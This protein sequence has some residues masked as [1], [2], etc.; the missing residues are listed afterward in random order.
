MSDYPVFA[1]A[2]IAEAILDIRSQLPKESNL[3]ILEKFPDYIQERF[4]DKKEQRFFETSIKLSKA[5]KHSSFQT[6]SGIEGYIFQ[7]H[8]AKKVVQSRLDGF[9]FNKLKPYTNWELFRSEGHE[10]W[11]IYSKIAK[12]IKVVR[13]ALRYINRIEV[14]LPM[15]DFKDYLLTTPEIAT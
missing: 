9:T 2:P 1:N 10:L 7:S 8:Q 4:P 13:I 14:P 3:K 15:K 6:A 12:P 11:E 5:E